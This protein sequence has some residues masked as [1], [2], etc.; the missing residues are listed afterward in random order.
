MDW[1][2][3]ASL[4][5]L[6]AKPVVFKHGVQQIAVFRVGD[7][8]FAVDNRCP[9]EGYPLA[10][11][12][13]SGDCVLT[14]NW[15]N[16]KFRLKDGQCL[17]GGDNVRSYLA[18]SENGEVWVDVSP[19]P[20]SEARRQ[21]LQGLKAAFADRDFGRI[22][23]EMARLH[24]HGLDPADA[25]REAIAWSYDRFEYGTSDSHAYAG[26]ADW[27]CLA[28]T[29][30]DDFER[31]LICFAECVDHMAFDSLR[32]PEYRYAEPG[33]SFE[34]SVFLSAVEAEQH[35]R[36]EGMVAR[37]FMD[38]LHWNDLEE[39]LAAAA[40]AHYHDFGH[41]LIYIPKTAELIGILGER[42]ERHLTLPLSRQ[43]C[44][45]TR[46]DLIPD[47]KDYAAV[48]SV[49]PEP[50]L[51]GPA[52]DLAAP[53]PSGLKQSFTW[54]KESLAVHSVASIYDALLR[55]LARNMLHYDEKFG[56]AFDRPVTDSVGWLDFTHGVTFANAVR[57]VC[58]KYPA[59][60]RPGLLQMAC[61]LGRNS[62]YLDP[63]M[64]PE[65]WAVEDSPAFFSETHARLL[66][67]GIN[68]PIFAVHLLKTTLAVEAELPLASPACRE[69]LLAALNRFLHS[70][71]KRKHVR[72][73]A[74]QAIALVSRDFERY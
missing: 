51:T 35:V 30:G 56:V 16:W 69:S 1:R 49:L 58:T 64:D 13:I 24:F 59:L 40:L 27:L 4:D 45:A 26:A 14:C 44:Y 62:R 7:S 25:V 74:R 63:A 61:F 65:A 12:S 67:H 9:H 42:V 48:L 34:R 72:R 36:A 73:L 53:F 47:F 17:L 70:S 28:A 37:A 21:I 38:G 52:D 2:R 46:E 39:T 50:R 60:W 19:P 29:F 43:L 15:H 18:R 31:R 11:G 41:S 20:P 54:L 55:A 57:V 66:D 33:E 23:R 6:R 3:A 32:R 22:C 68:E 71:V 10:S 8:V 5:E